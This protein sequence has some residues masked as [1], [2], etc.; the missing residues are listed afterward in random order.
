[1]AYELNI[2]TIYW[3]QSSNVLEDFYYGGMSD[4][5]SQVQIQGFS[6]YSTSPSLERLTDVPCPAHTLMYLWILLAQSRPSIYCT[7][8]G[9]DRQLHQHLESGVIAWPEN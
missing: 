5:E 2:Y 1:M 7:K 9:A 8:C 6:S 3:P 4:H